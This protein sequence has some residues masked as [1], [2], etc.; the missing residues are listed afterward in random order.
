[1]S[2]LRRRLAAAAIS[3]IAPAVLAAAETSAPPASATGTPP[4]AA[5]ASG[6]AL[7][8]RLTSLPQAQDLKPHGPIEITA[9][10]TDATEGTSAIYSGHVNLVSDTLKLDGDRLELRQYPDHQFEAKITGA[11]AH[12]SHAGAGSDNPSM[13]ARARTLNYDSRSSMVDLI[14]DAYVERN[15]DTTTADTIHYNV[16]DRSLQAVGGKSQVRIVIQPPADANAPATGAVPDGAT[17]PPAATQ[18]QAPVA[19]EKKS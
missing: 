12:M 5:A 14:G 15:G 16:A 18:P 2:P 4:S 9:D 1:M 11:P 3:A 17:A 19:P 8:D 13:A 6:D 7:K 10:R